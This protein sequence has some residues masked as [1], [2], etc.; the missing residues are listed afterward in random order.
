MNDREI[1]VHAQAQHEMTSHGVALRTRCNTKWR[2]TKWRCTTYV[3]KNKIRTKTTRIEVDVTWR[4]TT[5]SLVFHA[6]FLTIIFSAAS[7]P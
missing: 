7:A 2:H 3:N 4:S 6:Y 1:C 5:Y